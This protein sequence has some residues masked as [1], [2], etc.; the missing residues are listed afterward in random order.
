MSYGNGSEKDD[1]W[2]IEKLVPRRPARLSPFRTESAVTSHEA[3]A[4]SSS[5]PA[6]AESERRLNLDGFRGV[7]STEDSSYTPEGAGLIK[8]VTIKRFID[9]YDFYDNFRKAALVYFDYKT[10]KC[11]FAQFYSYM[12]QYSQLSASQKNYYFYWRA[13]IRRGK[14]LKTD[15]S[16]LYLLVYEILNLPDKIPPEEGIRLL[17]SLWREY[18]EV[19]PRIDLYFSIWV[20]DYCLVHA[21]PCPTAYLRDF[22]FGCIGTAPIKEFYLSDINEVGISGIAPLLGYLS[23]YDWRRGKFAGEQ[24][25]DTHTS[26][27]Q[28]SYK[29]HMESAMY[30]L[31]SEIWNKHI[32]TDSAS[33]VTVTR[34]AFPNSLCTHTVKC[35]LEIEY[36]SLAADDNIRRGVTAAVRYTENKLRALLGVKSRLAVKELPDEYRTVIDRY[37]DS[38]FKIEQQRRREAE[39]PE[40]ERLYEAPRERMSFEGADEIERLSWSTT[41]RL[42]DTD[43]DD[44]TALTI[45]GC[46]AERDEPAKTPDG[47][48]GTAAEHTPDEGVLGERELAYLCH[49][50]G[51]ELAEGEYTLPDGIPEEALAESI[52]EAFLDIIGDVVLEPSECGYSLIEDYRK[53]VFEWLLKQME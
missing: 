15:Y 4:P 25:A 16:Y 30:L 43:T 37:F 52:N 29:K 39:R 50:Y 13:E 21:L 51:G 49:I 19:L 12:P 32:L 48:F 27:N 42:V 10:A 26:L 47:I 2:D 46:S 44:G 31:L 18:R 53:D 5:E 24:A 36:V 34:D 11:D 40:Y 1:F 3:D 9:K 23:D 6:R 20:E 41:A 7:K 33:T 22:I 28:E 38:Y 45:S 8:R 35:K 14:F 17:C